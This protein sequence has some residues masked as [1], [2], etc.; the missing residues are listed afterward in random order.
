MSSSKNYSATGFSEPNTKSSPNFSLPNFT[1]EL[2]LYDTLGVGLNSTNEEIR[3]AYRDRARQVHPDKNRHM[4]AREWMQKVNEAY[5]ILSDRIERRAYDEKLLDGGDVPVGQAIPLPVASRLSDKLKALMR[6]WAQTKLKGCQFGNLAQFLQD[7][8]EFTQFLQKLMPELTRL[9]KGNAALWPRSERKN[10]CIEHLS[11]HSLVPVQKGLQCKPVMLSDDPYAQVL[12]L[13]HDARIGMKGKSAKK[14]IV[15]GENV[16]IVDFSFLRNHD[17]LVL[18]DLFYDQS[19]PDRNASDEEL[20]DHLQKF[21]PSTTVQA[22]DIARKRKFRQSSCILCQVEVSLSTGEKISLPRY[23]MLQPQMVCEICRD[24]SYTEDMQCWVNAGLS[25]LQCDEPDVHA[26][27]GCLYMAHCSRPPGARSLL[28]DAQ[29]LIRLGSPEMVFPLIGKALESTSD[30]RDIVKAHLISSNALIQMA[31]EFDDKQPYE[32][33]RLLLTAK[34]AHLYAC[35]ESIQADGAFSLDE[36]FDKSKS[37]DS[38]III[39][40][41]QMNTEWKDAANSFLARLE[42]AWTER[43]YETIMSILKEDKTDDLMIA[44]NGND[45]ILEALGLFLDSKKSFL[46]RMLDEDRGHLLFFK[47]YMHLS[48]HKILSGFSLIQTA[49][50]LAPLS[51]W[52]QNAVI[53]IIIEFL[54]GHSTLLLENI[55]SALTQLKTLDSRSALK[56]EDISSL[57][58][59]PSVEQLQPPTCRQ[60][61][62]FS[63]TSGVNF[64][65]YE[66]AVLK[67]LKLGKWKERDAAMAYID[68]VT[69]C[70]HSSQVAICFVNAALWL[71]KHFAL[72]LQDTRKHSKQDFYVDKKAILWC[73]EGSATIASMSLHPAMQTYIFRLVIGVLLKCAQLCPELSTADESQCLVGWLHKLIYNIR[74]CPFWDNPT[75]LVSEALIL[76]IVTGRLHSQYILALQDVHPDERPIPNDELQY[77][78]YENDLRKLH[79]L[80]DDEGNSKV[81]AMIAMLEKKGLIMEDV[82]RLLT[83]PL[84]PRSDEGWLIQQTTLGSCEEYSK[85]RGF[86]IDTDPDKPSVSILVDPTDEMRGNIGL[87]STSDISTVL[88]LDRETLL[89]L[90]FSL[91][92]PNSDQHFHPFQE[93]RFVPQTLAGTDLLQTLFETDYLL[94]SFSVGSD[95]S[96]IPPFNQRPTHNGLTKNLPLELQELLKPIHERGPSTSH[97]SRFWIQADELVYSC[98]QK[99]SQAIFRV[100]EPKMSVRTHPILPGPDGKLQDTEHEQDPDSPE[101][102]FAKGFTDNYNRIAQY[103]PMFARL[104]ELV[105]LQF[106]VLAVTGILESLKEQSR[107]KVSVPRDLLD[108]IRKDSAKAMV[109]TLLEM[110]K[111]IQSEIERARQHN[112]TPGYMRYIIPTDEEIT[113]EMTDALMKGE[114]QRMTRYSL[115][116]YVSSWISSNANQSTT[117]ELASYIIK[118]QITEDDVKQM[119]TRGHQQRFDAFNRLINQLKNAAKRSASSGAR[120]SC[121][122]VP[123]ALYEESILGKDAFFLSY[124]GVLISPKIREGYVSQSGISS[125]RTVQLNSS[126]MLSTS[127]RNLQSY[128]SSRSGTKSGGSSGSGGRSG[129]SSGSGGRSGG[130]SGSGG[131]S[132][133]SSGSGGRSGGSSGSGGRSGGSSGSGGRSGG[134]SGSGGRSGGSSGS[135]GKSGGSSGSGGKSG[136]SS[137]SGG[138]SGGSSG[139]GGR[140]GGSSESGGRSGG[141][142]GCGG[143]SGGSSGSG[144]KSGGS[145]GSGSKSGGSSGSGD[146]SGGS[147]GSGGR[148]GGSSKS[149][150]QKARIRP[151]SSAM[152][153]T[154]QLSNTVTGNPNKTLY[155]TITNMGKEVYRRTLST[156]ATSE[157]ETDNII[158]AEQRVG[159]CRIDAVGET[160]AGAF[161]IE[162]KTTGNSTIPN[163]T[164]FDHVQQIL[165]YRRECMVNKTNFEASNLRLVCLTED[166][167]NSVVSVYGVN[168]RSIPSDILNAKDPKVF[169][170]L[171]TSFKQAYRKTR[172]FSVT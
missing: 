160:K 138:R 130:S 62:E 157:K 142:S 151:P 13:L 60:W 25:F 41:E 143:K 77:H 169:E 103:F 50:L 15:P 132:G 115:K 19:F 118:C 158:Q 68:L 46:T 94:K 166:G 32:K 148:L 96:S 26:G 162:Y 31:K 23:G 155:K 4:Q 109:S 108:N 33:W 113:T 3:K 82:S 65:K 119:I 136:R 122:W 126:K 63:I 165:N 111:G 135:G 104:K 1:P 43:D 161:I 91:D 90:F 66:A 150:H 34:E 10:Q 137:G 171:F 80:E 56:I 36:M 35:N 172:K 152:L 146:K 120:H 7:G 6:S 58:L 98:E 72:C 64:F 39:A 147:S 48:E 88:H 81:K 76:H 73:C 87:F 145:S 21:I 59:F 8:T 12:G 5:R 154:R 47:G 85:L 37:I 45:Y 14:T 30:T 38:D 74:F 141:S 102:K 69:A 40:E 125:A 29:E 78:L 159:E 128:N 121:M 86:I 54:S 139:S 99:G 170:E 11:Y 153:V 114:G 134:S 92:P 57:S 124:G 2:N 67:Q 127:S 106:F 97:I 95:I 164:L 140:S 144:G 20:L 52:L 89:P 131:R 71:L 44:S 53:D 83:S 18:L 110:Y 22:V 17:L 167:N 84:S 133:G 112:L 149:G 16:P 117:M 51:S 42:S 70:E 123:A 49:T 101:V 105:K 93:F 55:N 168:L 116:S 27:V 24:T 75:V 61:P 156:L 129:G 79:P 28:Q 107:E 9:L 163:H 100:S